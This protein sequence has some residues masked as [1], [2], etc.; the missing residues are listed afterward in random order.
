MPKPVE[1]W[2]AEIGG[3]R[4]FVF[5]AE[6]LE[7]ADEVISDFDLRGELMGTFDSGGNA[8]WDGQQKITLSPASPEEAEHWESHVRS[9]IDDELFADREEALG[10]G[11]VVYLFRTYNNQDRYG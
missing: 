5:F 11:F 2:V 1:H 7:L 8:V 10:D 4:T 3:R 6:D 9:A